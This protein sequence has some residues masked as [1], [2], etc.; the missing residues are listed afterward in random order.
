MERTNR[1]VVD[2]D[3]AIPTKELL[4]SFENELTQP[5]ETWAKRQSSIS[6]SREH[7]KAESSLISSI[8]ILCDIYLFFKAYIHQLS[9]LL[10]TGVVAILACALRGSS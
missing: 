2:V 5:S 1:Q 8:R 4:A 3:H 6:T 7:W 10:L 9:I